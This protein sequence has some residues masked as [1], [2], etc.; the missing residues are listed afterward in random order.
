MPGVVEEISSS[1]AAE[2]YLEKAWQ[3]LGEDAEVFLQQAFNLVSLKSAYLHEAGVQDAVSGLMQ[4][5]RRRYHSTDLDSAAEEK[6]LPAAGNVP[7]QDA[8]STKEASPEGP[9]AAETSQGLKPNSGNGADMETY[10]WTQT[11]AEVLVSIPIPRGTKGRDC[12]VSIQ[13]SSVS[14]GLKGQLPVIAGELYASVK[15]DD[16]LWSI[17]DGKLLEVTLQKVDRMQWWRAVVKGQP[18]IDTQKVEPEN[19]QL[20][21]LDSETRATVEKMMYD[22]RQKALGLPT[23]D[24]QKKED[25]LKQFMAAHPEMDFSNAKIA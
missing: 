17:V 7:E 22:Q 18:E 21:D 20:G 14:I 15:L 23:S 13:P 1:A 9:A 11:L 8:A 5:A 25:I 10:S 19:S 4:A 24:E 12:A 6:A 3:E 16:C 2:H